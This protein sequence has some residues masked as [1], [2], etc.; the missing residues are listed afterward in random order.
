MGCKDLTESATQR[1]LISNIK[2]NFKQ[3]TEK[4]GF[5]HLTVFRDFRDVKRICLK[6]GILIYY[7]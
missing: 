7:L 2:R 4:T 5:Y 3:E 6:L 1:Y